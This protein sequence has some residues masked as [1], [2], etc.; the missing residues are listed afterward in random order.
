MAGVCMMLPQT[1]PAEV[2]PIIHD[3][4][5]LLAT[6]ASY[7][8]RLW[9]EAPGGGGYWGDGIDA[10]NQNGAVRGSANTL[11][12]YAVLA[13]GLK[14][15][16]VDPGDQDMLRKSGLDEDSL[17]GYVRKDLSYLIAHHKSATI[18]AAPEWG[19]GWQTSLWVQS[20]GI[21]SLCVWSD[22]S[23]ELQHGMMTVAGS[24]ADRLAGLAPK[25]MMPGD[26]GAEENG[27]NTGAFAVAVAIDPGSTSATRWMDGLK[28]FAANT[29]SLPSEK[30]HAAKATSD[31]VL[32]LVSTA[33]IMPDYSVINHGFFHPD[34]AQVS[35][36]HLGEALM[37]L[38][39][40][41][42]LNHTHQSDDF[43]PF[44]EHNVL[45]VW[46][47]V[48]RPLLQ[49]S[50]EFLFP[51]GNDWTFHCSTTQ[52]YFAWI[53]T[54]FRD[55]TAAEGERRG[56]DHIWRR[57]DA[58]P[59]GRLLGDS[60]LEWWWEPLV[61]KRCASAL[62]LHVLNT[63]AEF[64]PSVL[65]DLTTDVE[66]SSGSVWMHRNADYAVTVTW[67][68][69]GNITFSPFAGMKDT[70]SYF[71]LPERGQLVKAGVKNINVRAES[72][73]TVA[74]INGAGGARQWLICL[75]HSI[76]LISP[77]QAGPLYIEND[78]LTMPG[79]TVVTSEG[80]HVFP[81][82]KPSAALSAH[83]PFLNIDDQFN[84]I[85]PESFHYDP[86]GK[87]NHKSVATDE[88]TFLGPSCCCQ[89]FSG[90][91]RQ[92]ENLAS[93]LKSDRKST[94]TISLK[95]RD[96]AAGETYAIKV[97]LDKDEVKVRKTA[98]RD[99][100]AALKP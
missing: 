56:L 100:A 18:Q 49:P 58:G 89:L 64:G 36:Q 53:A 52:A 95:L 90:T 81:A 35:G 42:A 10:K 73:A 27:W 57:R 88:I 37:I 41:D 9:H 47:N 61:A 86:A 46:Q 28:K 55:G 16:W 82:L 33:N 91:A 17:L 70:S 1:A 92:A 2:A 98:S 72:D 80:K 26:T 65:D 5:R 25:D 62:L 71:T 84:V 31:P 51:A 96:G 66:W 40:G 7:A 13:K 54:E 77:D 24:E 83:G 79:R 12:V 20:M 44:A 99:T 32:S 3:Y 34:Y 15:G 63:P 43:Q 30:E 67:S 38:E 85:G 68:K 4:S 14:E 97:H 74:T 6:Y 60:N 93:L 94:N 76:A 21:A 22:I 50:G 75:P 45:A 87:W 11:M 19:F 69:A 29:Y 23:P 48:L 59:A 8:T 78:S 39:L